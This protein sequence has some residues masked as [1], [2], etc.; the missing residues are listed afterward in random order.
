M[1]QKENWKPIEGFARYEVSDC[2]RVRR[3]CDGHILAQRENHGG[4]MQLNLVVERGRKVTLKVHRLVALAFVTGYRKGLQVNHIDADTKNNHASNLEWVTQREN[5]NR[6]GH[7][8]RMA[9]SKGTRV[10]QLDSDG[11]I[12]ASYYSIAE[13]ARRTGADATTISRN[14]KG[15]AA[16]AHGFQWRVSSR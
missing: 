5:L 15:L 11:R 6:S 1:K 7:N 9:Q 16:H 13:A 12:I 3:T 4:Y 8:I 10:E 2:G 14:I